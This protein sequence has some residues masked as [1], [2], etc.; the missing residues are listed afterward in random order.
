V[1]AE[2]TKHKESRREKEHDL[3]FSKGE[4]VVKGRR[5]KR[6]K[7]W[8][9]S[10]PLGSNHNPTAKKNH[11]MCKEAPPRVALQRA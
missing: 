8:R 11:E 4:M 9:K 2:C 7:S 1:G 10:G 5:K 6:A 3:M